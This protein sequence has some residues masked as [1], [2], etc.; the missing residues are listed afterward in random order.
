[1]AESEF[2]YK[3]LTPVKCLR[4]LN[5]ARYNQAHQI[6]VVCTEVR[7][8][9]SSTILAVRETLIS[10]FDTGINCLS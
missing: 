7:Y 8:V 6:C 9:M 1:M 10:N 4:M 3:L 5:C 2:K